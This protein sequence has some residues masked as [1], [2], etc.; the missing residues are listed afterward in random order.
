MGHHL[1]I[2][3][4]L[5]FIV[6]RNNICNE[7]RV[8]GNRDANRNIPQK[9]TQHVLNTQEKKWAIQTIQTH[10]KLNHLCPT[11]TY[12][13]IWGIQDRSYFLANIEPLFFCVLFL[14]RAGKRQDS[15]SPPST[16]RRRFAVKKAFGRHHHNN[17]CVLFPTSRG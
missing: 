14:R 13:K 5:S 3:Y 16:T 12:E 6:K 9:D 10:Q 11:S 8:K 1:H 15:K 4:S 2:E 7:E 17:D